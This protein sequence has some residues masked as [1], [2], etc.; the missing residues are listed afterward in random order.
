MQS[1]VDRQASLS[2]HKRILYG[3]TLAKVVSPDNVNLFSGRNVPSCLL[4]RTLQF[5]L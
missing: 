1:R 5:C 4:H 3:N 2:V